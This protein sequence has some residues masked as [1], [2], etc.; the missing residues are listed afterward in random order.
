MLNHLMCLMCLR[1]PLFPLP[2]LVTLHPDFHVE[3][4]NPEGKV[5][6]AE[7]RKEMIV[8]T[9]GDLIVVMGTS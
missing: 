2:W 6:S 1:I 3:R 9:K 8:K 7:R 5:C 4:D